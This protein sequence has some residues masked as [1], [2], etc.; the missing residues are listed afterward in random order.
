MF[1]RFLEKLFEEERNENKKGNS[2]AVTTTLLPWKEDRKSKDWMMIFLALTLYLL[3]RITLTLISSSANVGSFQKFNFQRFNFVIG[4]LELRSAFFHTLVS[5]SKK[6]L[7][8][9]KK[10]SVWVKIRDKLLCVA[11]RYGKVT[12]KLLLPSVSKFKF[13]PHYKSRVK[14]IYI[15]CKS[16]K[17]SY[18]TI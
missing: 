2:Q 1:F 11:A 6:S 16:I 4:N 3:A 10:Y 7:L 12:S 18:K 15:Q 8:Y 9:V 13:C 5:Y 14:Q 17:V